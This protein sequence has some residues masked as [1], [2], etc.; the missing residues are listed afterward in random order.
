MAMAMMMMTI[1]RNLTPAATATAV[2]Q[3]LGEEEEEEK[4][5]EKREAK[6]PSSFRPLLPF[7][8]QSPVAPLF[9]AQVLTDRNMVE[10]V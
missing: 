1:G 6:N 8:E 10:F 4:E 5:E 3:G 2:L 7:S 9:C